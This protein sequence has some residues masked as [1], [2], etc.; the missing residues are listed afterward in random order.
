MLNYKFQLTFCTFESTLVVAGVHSYS[1][2][3]FCSLA[4]TS[5]SSS[6]ILYLVVTLFTVVVEFKLKNSHLCSLSACIICALY[7][8]ESAIKAVIELRN[9]KHISRWNRSSGEMEFKFS[10]V[11]GYLHL[12]LEV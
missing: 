3:V 4:E 9:C 5:I 7:T 1:L 8:T 12:W 11:I 10:I 6:S 2:S